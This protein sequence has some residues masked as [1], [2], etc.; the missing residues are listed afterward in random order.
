MA[1]A[2]TESSLLFRYLMD[3]LKNGRRYFI[4]FSFFLIIFPLET[5]KTWLIKKLN[6]KSSLLFQL[7]DFFMTFL[8]LGKLVDKEHMEKGVVSGHVYGSYWK[9]VGYWLSPS[10][11]LFVCLMTG[12]AILVTFPVIYLTLRM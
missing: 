11:I 8:H 3:D 6:T 4:N 5:I 1:V 2:N 7:Y 9:A 12:K 10:I